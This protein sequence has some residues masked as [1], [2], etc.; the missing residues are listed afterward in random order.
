M[1]NLATITT[2]ILADSGIDDINV[3]VSTGSY[4]DP[5]WIT[6]L[7]WTKITGAPANIVTGTGSVGQVAYWSS[8]SA[9]TG[10]SNLFWDATNDRL[11]VGTNSP[12]TRFE[13]NGDGA[14][15]VSSG[16]VGYSLASGA[17]AYSFYFNDADNSYRIYSSIGTAD[18]MILSSAGNLGLGVTPSAW[19]A[20]KPS[21]QVGTASI[22]QIANRAYFTAN[23][24]FNG[25][26]WTYIDSDFATQYFQQNGT[27]IWNTVTSGT[28]GNAISF[29][30][31]M[32][33]WSNSGLSIGTGLVAP[34][35]GLLVQGNVGIGVSPEVKLDVNGSVYVRAGGILYLD[36]IRGYT[37][38]TLSTTLTELALTNNFGIT[39]ANV[40]IG[41]TTPDVFGRF[42]T[43]TLGL[44]SSGSTAIQ[45]NGGSGGYGQIDFGAAGVRTAG[46]SASANETQWGSVTGIPAI[47]YTNG[48]T[49]LTIHGTTGAA[50]FSSSVTSL[51]SSSLISSVTSNPSNNAVVAARW[52]S[53]N[54][55]EM[56]YFPDF[57]LGYI[58]NTYPVTIGEPYGDIYFRQNVGGTMTTR[59]T[60]KA[61]G[62]NVGIGTTIPTDKF[63]MN[64]GKAIFA[65][66][67]FNGTNAGGSVFVFSDDNNGGK[68]WAQ[69]DGNQS[70]GYL[71]LQPAG[72]NVIVGTASDNGSRFQVTGDARIS[73]VLL[74]GGA[75]NIDSSLAV[76]ISS[77][78]GGTQ[79]W[80]GANKNGSYGLLLGYSETVGLSGVGAY[81][82]QVTSDPLFFVVNNATTALTLASTGAATFSSS[83]TAAR[84][85][86]ANG[87]NLSWGGFYGA[88]IPT[89]V[90]FDS[91]LYFY[92]AGSTSGET[93]RIFS[94]GNVFIGSSPSNAG[95]KLDVNGTGRF[96][97]LVSATSGIFSSV[98]NVNGAS[99]IEALNV[100]G[101]IILQGT[102]NRYIRL[103]S[104]TNYFYNLSSVNDDFQILEAGS[105]PRL[106]IK[107]PNGNVGIGTA[108]PNRK[109]AVQGTF[110]SNEQLLYLKQGDDNGFSFNLDAAV[111]GNLMVK[112]VNSGT[113]TASLLTI[114]RDNGNVGIGNTSPANRL[115]VNGKI[116]SSTEVQGG[117]AVMNLT[118]GYATFGSNSSAVGVRVGRDAFFNDIIINPSGNVTIGSTTDAGFKLDVNGTGRFSGGGSNGYLYVSGNA[119][120]GGS[121]N[122]AYLQGMNFSWNKS[123]GGGESL[124]TYTNQGGGSNIRFG[125]GYWN[126]STYS[127]QFTLNSSGNLGLGTTPDAW[128]SSWRALQVGAGSAIAWTGAGANDFSFSTNSFFDSTDNRWE[129]RSTGDGAARYSMTALGAEHRWF[130]APTGTAN[131]PITFTQVMTLTNSG[132]LLVGSGISDNG[133]TIQTSGDIRADY[134]SSIYLQ[135]NGGAAGD[136]RKGFSGINQESGVARGLHIFNYD[137]D[138]S[139][140]IKFYGGTFGSRIR[141]GGFHNDGNFFINTADL[142][143]G[144]KLDVNGTGRFSDRL[145]INANSGAN[146]L[147]IN[148]RSSDNTGSIDF[149]QNNGTT[150]VMEIGISPTAAEFYYDANSPMIFY[151]NG[152]P[153][154]TIANSGAAT[155]SSS[156]TATS[157]FESSD[158]TIKK[159]VKDNYQAK[160]IESVVAKLYI[161]NGK[162]ELGYYAQ[163]LEGALPSA[164]SKGS[165]GLLNL[166]YREVHTAKIAYLEK[167]IAELKKQLKNN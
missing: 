139:Q 88:G 84:M 62:G 80:F 98:V 166:S 124:L 27:H 70:W 110:T 34:A 71:A 158:A 123:N 164:V 25:T 154:L 91:A 119:G 66:S 13:V 153:R 32:T 99:S 157:F 167:E 137:P 105:I 43:R 162:Q 86:L 29:T 44:S 141:F 58:Q 61:D 112:G 17:D 5:V 118:S 127:E 130:T 136:Y 96:S 101:N 47:I 93:M 148:G 54:G 140:G 37:S 131:Q 15:R 160:G 85:V 129:Y 3:V 159:L 116:L 151:T 144:F 19:V 155:F 68:I 20:F 10:E 128:S 36:S 8:G 163:D 106:T 109:L 22:S 50:T 16:N 72:G 114:R 24:F 145:T 147:A 11:G 75:A 35:Q 28:A 31:A 126:N 26:S 12:A 89:I 113:E 107:Y 64:G 87:D 33:L 138:S 133:A 51:S 59:M 152:S 69:K 161:K 52:T 45:I 67:N 65:T 76:Q 81:I 97:S 94:D 83:V 48:A 40:G 77:S 73:N 156:V 53:G 60:I 132:R 23:A 115:D 134:T 95:F 41:T 56:A 121:T 79:K 122:P 4:A 14:F 117:S 104:A 146:A 7:A 46:I 149:F 74:A 57:A 30:Q 55:M 142:N 18:R 9:I 21:L 125:I 102:A 38:G 90:G 120:A 42:Y 108:S 82:R 165:D 100:N 6:S 111:T 63:Q 49:R 2:N 92:P 135:I 78:G 150:R 39:G 103:Q 1:A 143:A